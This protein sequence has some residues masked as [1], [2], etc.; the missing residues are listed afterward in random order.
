MSREQ[1]EAVERLLRDG[2]L[3]MGGEAP[4]Q[5]VIFKQMMTVQ[6]LAA[7]VITRQDTLGGVPVVAI[8]VAGTESRGVVVYFHGG[9]YALGTAAA[10]A[11]LAS[12]VARSAGA[13]VIS[14]DY[15]LA[16]E[17]PYPAAV[18]DALAVW[19]GLLEAG[20]DPAETAFAGESAGGGLAMAAMMAA[21]DAGLPLP[22]SAVL[23]SP[24]AD[25]TLAGPS[26]TSKADADPALTEAGLRRRALDYAA[27]H[28]PG[29]PLISPVFG[30]LT[31]LPALLIQA[32]SDEILLDD[33][34]RLAARAAAGDVPVTLQVT[35][36]MPH[37]FQG[38]A[39]VLDEAAA[40]LAGAGVFLRGHLSAGALH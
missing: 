37:V 4:E 31:G 12:D 36:G 17:H 1:R 39:A 25:L 34:T 6:P 14:V 35:P 5:R 33:A 3:D 10:T 26:M 19:R 8:D 11:G 15:R 2:P 29:Q 18:D 21:R 7:D 30:N 9:G 23:M 22:S 20:Q 28:N 27:G 38:F 16:P 40:A 13:R 32:G 24:W